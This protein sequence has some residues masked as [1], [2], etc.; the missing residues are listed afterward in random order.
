MRVMRIRAILLIGLAAACCFLCHCGARPPKPIVPAND[1][2]LALAGSMLQSVL[3]VNL[4]LTTI[5]GIGRVKMRSGKQLESFRAIWIGKQPNQ[6]R[7]DVLSPMGQPVYSFACDGDRIYLFSYSGNKL[8]KRRATEN[9]LK[10][11][12]PID[13]TV[14]DLLN[15]ISGR[16]PVHQGGRV[17]LEEPADSEP[18][19]VL[20]EEGL[21]Y[22]ETI[23]L[24]KDRITPLAFE[25]RE[26]GGKLLF[27]VSFEKLRETEGFRLPESITFRDHN[28][29]MI[30]ID[31]ERA[32]VNPELTDDKFVLNAL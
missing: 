13:I 7:L 19:L 12:I 8:Y 6:F 29:G 18:L 22:F 1:A 15:L 25:R 31:V 30:H 3:S 20:H 4:D 27:E 11:I 17:R 32:W 10:R 16:L 23:L 26:L 24:D 9:S 2:T 21:A 5:K 28:G 14:T